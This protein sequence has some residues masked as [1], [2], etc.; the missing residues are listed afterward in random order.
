MADL[1]ALVYQLYLEAGTPSLDEIAMRVAEDDALVGS[2]LRDTIGRIIRDT[3][4]PPSQADVVAVVTVLA[5]LARWDAH[6]AVVRARD[7]WVTARLEAPMGVPLADARDPFALEVH[8]SIT[9]S[10]QGGLPELPPYVSRA[11]DERLAA[12]VDRALGGAS[13][14][15]T[16]VAGSSAG[17]TRACWEALEPLRS[18]GGWRLWHPYNPTR[19][20]AALQGLDRV[21]PYTVVWLNEA[22]EYL[23]PGGDGGERVAAKLRALLADTDRAPVL[24]L[25]TLWPEHHS[26]LT[27]S[28]QVRQV[29]EGTAIEVSETFTDVD[30]AAVRRAARNDPRLAWAFGHADD[31]QITQCLAGGPELLE[32]LHTAPPCP[33]A[34]ML[35]AIDAR[36]MGHRNALPLSL[37]EQAAEAYLTDTQWETLGGDWLEQALAHTSRLCKGAA[38]PLTRLRVSGRPGRDRKAAPANEGQPVYRLADYLD[39]HGRTHHTD[40]IPPVGF[41]VALAAHAHPDDMSDLADA[42]WARG[43]Y[44]D[45]VQL[46]K[47]ATVH[48]DP[49]SARLLVRRLWAV[50]P[51]DLR[52]GAWVAEHVTL[53]NQ[54]D[55]EDLLR[56]LH[57]AGA[58]NHVAVLAERVS[59]HMPVGDPRQVA[60]LLRTLRKVGAAD[61]VT[62]LAERAATR[63]SV[64]GALWVADLLKELHE[65]GAADFVAA[66]AERAARD[67]TL[68]HPS[69]VADLLGALH[70]VGAGD[71]AARLLAR[72]PATHTT[73]TDG[74]GVFKLLRVL[75]QFEA[76]DQ[77]ATLAERVTIVEPSETRWELW[78]LQKLGFV[79]PPLVEHL[80]INE[81]LLVRWALAE[82][83]ELGAADQI[84]ALLARDPATHTRLDMPNSV[85]FL[86]EE[87][88]DVGATDQ[89]ATL[90][91]RIAADMPLD[92]PDAVGF[93]LRQL[94]N[95]GAGA[96]VEPLSARIATDIS[97]DKPFPLA[98]ILE[99]LRNLGATDQ[100]AV[101]LDRDPAAHVPLGDP[102]AIARM[103]ETLHNLGATD[104]VAVLL[105]R[106]PAAHVPLGDPIAIARMLETLHNLGAT[107]QVAVLLDRDPAAHVPLGQPAAVAVLLRALRAA[108]ATEQ[109]TTLAQR[110]AAD[111]THARDDELVRLLETLLEVGTPEQ[112]ATLIEGVAERTLFSDH[113][114]VGPLL[115]GMPKADVAEQVAFLLAPRI[116]DE[117]LAY[118]EPSGTARL[119]ATL[120]KLGAADQI[121]ALAARAATT[122][123][124]P[125]AAELAEL[126]ALQRV[127]TEDQVA[128]LLATNPAARVPLDRPSA[129]AESLRTLLKAG[130][131][132]QVAVLLARDPATRTA[133]NTE[134][135]GAKSLLRVLREIGATDQVTVLLRRLPAAGRFDMLADLSGQRVR[136]R[137]GREPDGRAAAPWAWEDLD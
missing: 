80:V 83:R 9:L 74:D 110:A 81:P 50:H 65:A 49:R 107:D 112:T 70:S 22:Q 126:T 26:T 27:R 5:R 34:L 54:Q 91:G 116:D 25:G 2:P 128:A 90:A 114:E 64:D 3:D 29:L 89:V 40:R 36:R 52:P 120:L 69:A 127:G 57:E 103:L 51:T 4:V 77:V 11:H 47:N 61:G 109:V 102:I 101:L 63:V 59:T 71:Q 7:L 108:G 97:L 42:A 121:V 30:L 85:W 98:E 19:V 56:Q 123:D 99:T 82:L 14:M 18:A 133:L 118:L 137:F 131:E 16:L 39:Q 45:A 136:F 106:D 66:L 79:C 115:R 20:E 21:G 46:H 88:S 10:G 31:G 124:S 94:D 105:D 93:M 84:A 35:A 75:H 43:L 129:V 13:A 38:G 86:L 32:R 111:T 76:V 72:D 96:Q 134:W 60:K 92:D 132:E 58:A 87:L 119:L 100:V 125:Q 15:A 28:S 41:W 73:L 104:Q 95:L 62:V 44:R 135:W 53:D 67:S 1:K 37:L 130:A 55:V 113:S 68:R 48:G 23:H 6:A 122:A 33:K 8:R 117:Y 12:I 17:K 78:Q 24:V